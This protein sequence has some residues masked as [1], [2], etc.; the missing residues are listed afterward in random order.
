MLGIV[1]KDR[2]VPSFASK[3]S[4]LVIAGSTG[5]DGL[6]GASFASRQLSGEDEIGVSPNR[7]CFLR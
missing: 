3:P 7:G 1:K 5:I 6:G 4:F 2:I